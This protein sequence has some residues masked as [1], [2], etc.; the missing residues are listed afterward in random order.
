MRASSDGKFKI[1]QLT[2]L[3]FGEDSKRDEQTAEFIKAWATKEQPDLIAITGD[4][5]SGFYWDQQTHL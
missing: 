2:D 3:H 5:I 1:M 4:L